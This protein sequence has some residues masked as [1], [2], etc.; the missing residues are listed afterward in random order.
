[1]YFSVCCLNLKTLLTK[2]ALVTVKYRP[3][4]QTLYH[5]IEVRQYNTSYAN[6]HYKEPVPIFNTCVN[7]YI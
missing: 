7:F 4:K 1:M 2:V 5:H 6:K 3:N